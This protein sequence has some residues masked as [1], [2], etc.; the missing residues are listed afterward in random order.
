[1]CRLQFR[2]R[3]HQ[4]RH[5]RRCRGDPG[6]ERQ[7]LPVL[8]LERERLSGRGFVSAIPLFRQRRL[9]QDQEAGRQARER[10]RLWLANASVL[11]LSERGSHQQGLQLETDR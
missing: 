4:D 1:M 2:H 10:H 9:L 6:T 11:D 8:R 3:V 7:P 5:H